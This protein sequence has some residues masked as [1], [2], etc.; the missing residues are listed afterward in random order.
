ML[1]QIDTK[2]GAYI[3]IHVHGCI[4]ITRHPSPR[5]GLI[6]GMFRF[7]AVRGRGREDKKIKI[8]GGGVFHGV[9]FFPPLETEVE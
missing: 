4:F 9:L 6:F 8:T 5:R 2:I 7:H 1:T 3:L